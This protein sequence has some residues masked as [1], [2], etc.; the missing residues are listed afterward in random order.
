V[1]TAPGTSIDA[2]DNVIGGDK[3]NVDAIDVDTDISESEVV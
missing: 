2:I 3:T 1:L